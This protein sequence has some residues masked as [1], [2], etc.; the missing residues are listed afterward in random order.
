MQPSVL[1]TEKKLSVN[2]VTFILAV[3]SIANIELLMQHMFFINR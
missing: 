1:E 3:E 2:P